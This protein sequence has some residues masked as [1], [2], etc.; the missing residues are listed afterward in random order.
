MKVIEYLIRK[1]EEM[2][3]TDVFGIPGGVVLDF[4]YAINESNK[5]KIHL[6]YNEQMAAYAACGYAQASGKIGIVYTT[7]GPGFTNAYTPMVEAYCDSLPV[8]FITA[9]SQKNYNGLVRIE[10]EQE[11]NHI[12]MAE[13]TTKY[14]IRI[15]EVEMAKQA[16]D[17]AFRMLSLPRKGPVLLD[18]HSSVFMRNM[19]SNKIEEENLKDKDKAELELCRKTICDIVSKSRRPLI[20]IGDGLRNSNELKSLEKFARNNNIPIISSRVSEDLLIESDVYYG[21]IGSH[22]LR[23]SNFILSKSDC[24]IAIGNRLVVNKLSETWKPILESASFIR[25]DIDSKELERDVVDSTNFCIDA[26]ELLPYI[27]DAKINYKDDNKWMDI[28]K[29]LRNKLFEY[30]MPEAAYSLLNII[31]SFKNCNTIINDVGNNEL[32]TSRI[33]CMCKKKNVK[34][35]LSKT[36]KTVGS[37]L[38]KAIGAYYSER[39]PVMCITG[40]EGL[41]YNIQELQYIYAHKLPIIIIVWN[42]R[43]LGMLKDNETNRKYP[44]YLHTTLDSGYSIPDFEKIVGAYGIEYIRWEDN[45]TLQS[46]NYIV[47]PLVIELMVDEGKNAMPKLP[48]GNACM[49]FIPRMKTTLFERL[50]SL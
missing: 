34:F 44:Y 15:D 38:G 35:L 47:K 45:Q 26:N 43:S 37:A 21:Y 33:L 48:R 7:K 39:E 25:I 14:A 6:N 1:I 2:E 41:Q 11:I 30:D 18:F 19:E 27:A 20:L 8:L 50:N 9:H 17:N 12:A 22:G 42:N 46:Y 16:I 24:I 10:E 29:E 3:I 28:C 40:D 23:Y 13:L 36:M 5:V 31:R 32:W 49:D 4:I